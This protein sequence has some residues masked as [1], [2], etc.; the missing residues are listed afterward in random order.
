MAD[1]EE[2]PTASKPPPMPPTLR[3][4]APGRGGAWAASHDILDFLNW[5][6]ARS[7]VLKRE[8]E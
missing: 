2:A 4:E 7:G 6:H 8:E 1:F 3:R 5:A